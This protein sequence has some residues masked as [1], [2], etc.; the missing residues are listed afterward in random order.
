MIDSYG[1]K[2]EYYLNKLNANDNLLNNYEKNRGEKKAKKD[3]E[4]WEK[5][6][7]LGEEIRD[8]KNSN[9]KRADNSI[10]ER[11][12]VGNHLRLFFSHVP[13]INKLV[14][15]VFMKNIKPANRPQPDLSLFVD[16]GY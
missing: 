2:Y 9:G 15:I 6:S 7:W 1:S 14:G 16:S 3:I 5:R 13:L 11:S 4:L 12:R 10:I 8:L